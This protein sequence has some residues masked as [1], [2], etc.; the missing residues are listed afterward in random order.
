MHGKDRVER[1]GDEAKPSA[2]CFVL[3]YTTDP[4]AKETHRV[5]AAAVRATNTELADDLE[6]QVGP[7]EDR[8]KVIAALRE[9]AE[10]YAE[11]LD[12]QADLLT[13]TVNVLRGDPPP[14]VSWS[15]HDI[16]DLAQEVVDYARS[17]RWPG[18]SNPRLP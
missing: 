16:P 11:I 9:E 10:E 8:E 13:R 17:Q 6:S 5:Y 12:K 15:H 4:A 3:N 1:T 14:L 7:A 2:R 18:P